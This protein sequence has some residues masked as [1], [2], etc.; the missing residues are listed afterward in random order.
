MKSSLQY[1]LWVNENRFSRTELLAMV[2]WL[3]NPAV[4]DV[5]SN[6]LVME[7]MSFNP[8]NVV[9]ISPEV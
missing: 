3:H 1:E 7:M 4:M 2:Q 5:G 6:D 9:N 8:S